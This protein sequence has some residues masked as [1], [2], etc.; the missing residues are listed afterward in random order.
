LQ[1][2]EV[3]LKQSPDKDTSDQWRSFLNALFDDEMSLKVD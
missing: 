2:A 1:V 3:T